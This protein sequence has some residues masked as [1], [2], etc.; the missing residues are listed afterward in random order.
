MSD[1]YQPVE[2]EAYVEL[3][4]L[5][6]EKQPHLTNECPKGSLIDGV[7]IVC[8]PILKLSATFEDNSNNYRG[9]LLLVVDKDLKSPLIT[10]K[11]GPLIKNNNSSQLKSGQF[12]S[13]VFYQQ[14][15]YNFIRYNIDL[16]LQD[17]EQKIKYYIDGK[18]HSSY[19]F[20]IPAIDQS[21]NIIS[22]SCNGFSLG[23]DTL[24]YPS[25]LWLD[26]LRKHTNPNQHYHV[27]LGGGDQIYADSV[28]LASNEL[29]QWTEE[30]SNHKKRNYKASD[31]LFEELNDFYLHHYLKWFGKGFWI[32]TKGKTLQPLFPFTMSTIPSV[33]IYDDHDIIDGFGS[34]H[35][36]TMSSEVFSAIGNV[37]YKFYMI[38][39][40]QINPEEKLYE[41][42]PSWILGAKPGPFI[43]QKSHSTYIRLGKEISLLGVDCRTERKLKQILT[44]SSYKL[45]FD[46]LNRE[47]SNNPDI[48]HLLVMLGVPILYPRLVWLEWLLTSTAFKPIRAMAHKGIVAKGL[49][50]EFDGDIEVL[51][52]LNDHWCSKHHKRERNKLIK[53]LTEFGA[54]NG[55]RITILSGDVHLG[56]ISRIKSKYHKWVSAHLIS[57]R[58]GEIDDKNCR[59]TDNPE[60]DPRLIFNVI[61]S[62]IINA[63][64]PD[65]M[66]SLLN[67]RSKIHQ[68]DKYSEEDVIPL[69]LQEPK[70]GARA[71]TLFLNKRNWSDLIIAKQS[72]YRDQVND[73]AGKSVMKF[74]GPKDGDS[75][76]Q[77]KAVNN[78]WCKYPLRSDS[79]VTTLHVEKDANDYQASTAD[80]EV[81]IPRL[82]GQWKLEK[83][84][85]KHL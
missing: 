59:I 81:L 29:K 36:S 27:M 12:E 46:R 33:N 37:A 69:F 64:P 38:F 6:G 48:K 20:F 71:N 43:K 14:Q 62:A 57:N 16:Q 56:C 67:K 18:T 58:D 49:V 84:H 26:V 51:D 31:S 77:N 15:N 19:Q 10:Y 8:G 85:I 41:S 42:D 35:D 80:Y 32:G 63:P 13:T 17:V 72:M 22:F 11:I 2:I 76:L 1:F 66:A 54:V 40:H 4:R 45:I 21:M 39:Q 53:D 79:L 83:S 28:K 24:E 55:V 44:P 70:G 52:D 5:T 68:F 60:L 25:S 50:N 75:S 65:A 78:T 23:T 9:L 82:L 7:N 74:P 34:Y 61:S 3:N 73:V 47:I 30:K